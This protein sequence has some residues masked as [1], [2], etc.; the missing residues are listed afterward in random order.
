MRVTPTT[1][2]SF[3]DSWYSA[4]ITPSSLIQFAQPYVST[5]IQ[6]NGQE[7]YTTYDDG[8]SLPSHKALVNE[9]NFAPHQLSFY[10]RSSID[11]GHFE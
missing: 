4:Q 3:T 7:Q 6:A 5:T 8:H 11:L 10:P 9:Q 1:Y 2:P